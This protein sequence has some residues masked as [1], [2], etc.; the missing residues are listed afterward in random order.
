MFA[1][2]VLVSVITMK[3]H[4]Y[5]FLIYI[6]KCFKYPTTVSI[7]EVLTTY[8]TIAMKEYTF[9]NNRKNITKNNE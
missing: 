9:N 2:N 4:L 8:I 5:N 6:Q 1:D 3:K 7:I